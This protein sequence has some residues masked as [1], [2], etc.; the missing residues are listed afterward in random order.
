MK[1]IKILLEQLRNQFLRRADDNIKTV[2]I[3]MAKKKY[4][5]FMKL[6]SFPQFE[7][8]YQS[9]DV[10]M[11]ELNGCVPGA[12]H[13]YD[14]HSRCKHTIILYNEIPPETHTI[15]HEFT[16]ILDFEM[17]YDGSYT[18]ILTDSG[19][20]TEESSRIVEGRYSFR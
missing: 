17:Y 4:M 15:F 1:F 14:M 8:E 5:Y 6:E 19:A 11:Y 10:K 18:P 3:S 16:H 13:K 7:I 12:Q 9:L 2:L 20:L